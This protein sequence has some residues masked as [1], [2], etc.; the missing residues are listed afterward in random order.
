MWKAFHI[1][2]PA[3]WATMAEF[4][5]HQGFP[6]TLLSLDHIEFC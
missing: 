6:V 3:K 1:C 4:Q 5:D 2:N